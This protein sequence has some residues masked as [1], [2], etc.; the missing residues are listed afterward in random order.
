[1][2]TFHRITTEKS[3]TWTAIMRN[4]NVIAVQEGFAKKDGVNRWTY[5]FTLGRLTQ[6]QLEWVMHFP[7]VE[8][9]E[10]KVE[11]LVRPDGVEVKRIFTVYLFPTYTKEN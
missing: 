11:N 1:M 7:N 4:L 9:T 2:Q 10:R 5:A 8:V 6:K 3:C